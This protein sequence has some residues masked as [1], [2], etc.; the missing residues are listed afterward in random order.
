MKIEN[1]DMSNIKL[2]E[3]I[4]YIFGYIHNMNVLL[5]SNILNG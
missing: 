5:V 2:I 4:D 3:L 1:A